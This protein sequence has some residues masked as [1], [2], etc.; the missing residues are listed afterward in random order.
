MRK[1]DLITPEGTK[2]FLFEECLVRR[3]TEHKLHAIFRSKG[4]SELT[5]PGLE[6][7]DVFQSESGH[8][9]QER[10]YKMTDSKGRL[11][12][13]RPESTMP[14]AR[15]VATRLR[16]ASLPLRLYYNQSV[17]RFEPALK[18]RSDEIT[19]TGIELLGSASYMADVEMITTAIEVLSACSDGSFSLELGDAGVF[20]ELMRELNATPEERENIRYLIETKN[21]PALNDV[22]DTMGDSRA[23]AAL[24]KLPALFGGEEVFEKASQ[25]YS[26]QRIDEILMDLRKLYEDLSEVIGAGRLT[27]DLGMVNNADY[28][29][30]VII[31]GYLEGYG[32]EVLSGG[33]YNKLLSDFG[34]DIPATGFA[35]NVDAV[36][37]ILRK[38]KDVAVQP[39]DAVIYAAPG[40]EMKAVTVSQELRAK[41]QIVEY[42]FFDSIDLVR[43]YAK[44]RRIGRV[45][46]VDE[47][48]TEVE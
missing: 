35:V 42:A 2:D 22:L 40:Y 39:A 14:I 43:E 7:F 13:L 38:N 15:V 21:Y 30:G 6:F 27:V 31:K 37:N 4:Y 16:D 24:K 47:E 18:G 41:G 29:T 32:E 3:E 9:P 36:S 10:L 8:Y 45:V 1:Y 17:Y 5:T 12:V 46:I 34:Y 48:I 28:Y 23:A 19:Q 44:D 20:K 25:L 11:L 26:N 33:R